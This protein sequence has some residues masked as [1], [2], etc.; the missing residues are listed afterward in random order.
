[1][2]GRKMNEDVNGN[3]K[4]FW[5]KVSKAIGGKVENSNRIKDGYERLALEGF[6]KSIMRICII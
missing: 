1:M 6:G 5:R 3:R 4:L 2:F